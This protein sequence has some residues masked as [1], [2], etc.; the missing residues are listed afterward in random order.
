ML[1]SVED[2]RVA[3]GNIEAL[4]GISFHVDEGEIVTLIGANGAGKSTTLMTISRLIPA[5]SGVISYKGQ[6]LLAYK[7][8][9]VVSQLGIAH[10]PEGRRIFG[11]LTVL[12]NL[13]LAAWS[14]KSRE[15]V[16]RDLERVFRIFPRLAE[17]RNQL[18][19]TLSGGEQQM[20]SVGRALMTRGELMLLDEPSMGLAPVLMQELFQVLREINSQGTTILLVEQN[21][22][23]ALKLA[24]R[25][26]VLETG[27]I[28]LSG[29]SEELAN[30]PSVRKAYLGG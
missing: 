2:L 17:R 11:N 3:Y 23:L 7:P 28:T 18:G 13:K 27:N 22:H 19:D 21:A 15:E 16:E 6:D 12:E 8:H 24:K 26:Y 20:L 25:G 30:N 29:T 14:R 5:K 1:L 10:V 9:E 4:H